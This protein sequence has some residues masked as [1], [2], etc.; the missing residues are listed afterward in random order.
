MMLL[1]VRH[2]RQDNHATNHVMTI[3]CAKTSRAEQSRRHIEA[4]HSEI[5]YLSI[6]CAF[7]AKHGKGTPSMLIGE[8]QPF[9]TDAKDPGCEQTRKDDQGRLHPS[10]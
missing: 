9:G 7:Q 4:K 8:A 6:M 2:R 5:I 10:P 1:Q 3:R